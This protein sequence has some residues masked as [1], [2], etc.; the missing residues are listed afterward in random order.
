MRAMSSSPN[1]TSRRTESQ[2]ARD[3][4]QEAASIAPPEYG[5]DFVDRQEI[6]T[7]QKKENKTGLPDKLKSGVESLSGTAIDDV[8]VHYNSPKPASLHALAFTRGREIHV[9]PGQK[10]HLPHEAW[11]VVQQ[12]QGR[13]RPTGKLRG[14]GINED[15][16]LEREADVMGARAAR[17]SRQRAFAV[18]VDGSEAKRQTGS[19]DHT[20][21]LQMLTV[22]YHSHPTATQVGTAKVNESDGAIASLVAPAD[23]NTG[24]GTTNAVRAV[25]QEATKAFGKKFIAGHMLN[26]HLGGPGNQQSNITAFT[27]GQNALHHSKL[28]RY[29]KNEVGVQGQSISYYTVVTKRADFYNPGG[30]VKLAE[31]LASELEGG[32]TNL[33]TG[34]TFGPVTIPLGPAAPKKNEAATGMT[35]TSA[36]SSV[37]GSEEFAA[38][39]AAAIAEE[40]FNNHQADIQNV[41]G[42]NA[43]E[44]AISDALLPRILAGFL[45]TE[46]FVKLTMKWIKAVKTY[47]ASGMVGP[48]PDFLDT[49]H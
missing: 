30:T 48:A 28:E 17:G 22:N 6:G 9:G 5:I 33:G 8:R 32:Y 29:A 40:V 3:T 47:I 38:D 10:R 2:S 23:F 41:Y 42:P 4:G 39:I 49:F 36:G 18:G 43:D 27:G 14:V 31:N 21:P 16:R 37:F 26:D 7:I 24:S 13:V 12:K 34:G 35:A 11:H 15:R 25:S 1:K 20:A 19:P 46:K 45:D 44:D